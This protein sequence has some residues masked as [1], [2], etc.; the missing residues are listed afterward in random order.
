MEHEPVTSS[1]IESVGYD[2]ATMTLEVK[3]IKSGALYQ[4]FDVPEQEHY[5]LIH[6]GSVGT[7]FYENIKDKYRYLKL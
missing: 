4:F 2:P 7:Y 3:F 6:A 1:N 5:N